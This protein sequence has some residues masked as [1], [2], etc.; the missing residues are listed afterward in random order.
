M[1]YNGSNDFFSIVY[2]HLIF[3]SMGHPAFS[4]ELLH[5]P[6]WGPGSGVHSSVAQPPLG[7][8]HHGWAWAGGVHLLKCNVTS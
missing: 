8:V 1:M 6:L 4:K 7:C 5:K 2:C 3:K